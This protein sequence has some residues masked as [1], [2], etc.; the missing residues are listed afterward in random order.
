MPETVETRTSEGEKAT[1]VILSTFRAN[2]LLLAAGDLLATEH[3]L[4]SARWQVLGAVALAQRPLT[5][6][7]IARRMGLTRQSV[8]T[9]VN[10]LLAD[11]L[12]ELVPNADHRRSQLVRMTEVGEARYRAMDEKQAVWVN[13]LAA[14]L[15]RSELETAARVLGA[16]CTRLEAGSR[17]LSQRPKGD[18]RHAA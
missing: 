10:R 14:G 3:G 7:Q 16:L 12:V 9:T 6:P 5:V 2:G 18:D 17:P 1:E 11:G 13:E 15:R 4:T 8:H